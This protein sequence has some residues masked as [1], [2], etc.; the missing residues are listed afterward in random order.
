MSFHPETED[1]KY[2]TSEEDLRLKELVESGKF[3]FRNIG[4]RMKRTASSCQSHSSILGFH[5]PYIKRT[6]HHNK[7]FFNEPNLL[8]CYW[9][10]FIAA[11]GSVRWN[12]KCA[13]IRIEICDIDHL[14]QLKD[15]VEFNGKIIIKTRESRSVPTGT[16]S[17]NCKCWA[18]DLKNNFNVIEK[19]TKRLIPPNLNNNLLHLSFLLGYIDGDGCIFL[20]N[21]KNDGKM[22]FSIS[23]VSCSA[24]ILESFRLLVDKYFG[25]YKLRRKISV[26]KRH[27][28]S[29]N[30]SVF[31]CGGMQALMIFDFLRAFPVPKLDRKWNNP[32]I[33]EYL[34]EKKAE[35]PGFFNLTPELQTIKDQLLTYTQSVVPIT[36][37]IQ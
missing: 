1:Y 19:K 32:R 35:Y 37:N 4:E 10:G 29:P 30:A 7:K 28:G 25:E 14:K 2:W 21:A 26:I 34:E 11:D 15:D 22:N 3:D 16:M 18:D 31:F 33:L 13:S 8:N 17:V 6:Y 27:S 23:I 12:G 24:I 5:N 36:N 9:A 20:S